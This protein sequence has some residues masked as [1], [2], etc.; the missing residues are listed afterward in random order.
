MVFAAKMMRYVL[1]GNFL[2]LPA[3]S[4]PVR[5]LISILKF[6][7]LVVACGVTIHPSLVFVVSLNSIVSL[8]LLAREF[9][10][11][12]MVGIIV[13]VGYD[14]NGLPVGFQLIGRPWSEAKLLQTALAF[15]VLSFTSFGS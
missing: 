5:S 10:N 15:E 12:G 13:Q 4:I 8:H 7:N 11:V 9:Q 6:F 3:I 14:H 1:A 2:G